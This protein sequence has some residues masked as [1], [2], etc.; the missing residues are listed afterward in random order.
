MELLEEGESVMRKIA[1]LALMVFLVLNII[2]LAHAKESKF[3]VGGR[4]SYF[5]SRDR[6]PDTTIENDLGVGMNLQYIPTPSM[7]L[8]LSVDQYK[9]DAKEDICAGC[10]DNIGELKTTP[11]FLK[12]QFRP[13]T[14][15][16]TIPYFGIGGGR[17][18]NSFKEGSGLENLIYVPT[19]TPVTFD[20]DIE[21]SWAYLIN[22]GADHFIS[23]AWS[24]NLDVMYVWSEADTKTTMNVQGSNSIVTEDKIKLDFIAI[25][26]GA[27][28][29]F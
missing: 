18:L 25:G 13:I 4:L 29:H 27:R 1:S 6:D 20:I 9:L 5:N 28:Y 12:A 16:E 8:E 2:N 21:D 10:G 3:A 11:I 19:G 15:G 14:N 23:E 22:A 26:I 17:L 24:I 7:A